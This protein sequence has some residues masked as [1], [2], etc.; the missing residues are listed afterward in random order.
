[1]QEKYAI[2]CFLESLFTY[3]SRWESVVEE[4][5]TSFSHFFDLK[6]GNENLLSWESIPESPLMTFDIPEYR[7]QEFDIEE[8]C[9]KIEKLTNFEDL[10]L[11]L[12][13]NSAV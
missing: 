2:I 5:K 7:K 12:S 1:M 13:F 9:S 8:M 4:V 10:Y 11:F 3:D 6:I